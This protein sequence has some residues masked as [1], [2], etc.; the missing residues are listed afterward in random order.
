MGKIAVHFTAV[1]GMILNVLSA[2]GG[3]VLPSK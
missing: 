3:D 1:K 2:T